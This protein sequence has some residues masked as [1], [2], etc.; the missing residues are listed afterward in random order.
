MSAEQYRIV[1]DGELAPG[2]SADAVRSNLARLFKSDSAKIDRL[3]G[4]GPVNIK[5]DLSAPEADRY[6]QA[7][8]R[9]GAL[10]R[11]ELEAG[12][13]IT[14]T[15]AE[16]ESSQIPAPV[17]Q[18]ACPKCGH[19]QPTSIQCNSCGIVIQKYLARQAQQAKT[20]GQS[21]SPLPSG[22]PYAPPRTPVDE[23]MTEHGELRV[24]T[25]QG[26]IGR[27]R[28]LAWSMGLMAAAFGLW[29][30]AS[31]TLAVSVVLG[32][33]LTG[34]LGLGFLVVTVQIGVQRLHDL[35]WSGWL[36]L[37]NLV[38]VVGTLFP[39]VM[40]LMPGNDGM[41]RFGAPQPPNSRAVKIL[42]ALW[43]LV[44]VIG[45]LAAI[46]LPSVG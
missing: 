7:L 35:G 16:H 44:P 26:R 21:R 42:A 30:I 36:M 5:R 13:E 32:V 43:L 14:L 15:L 41:N 19:T 6:M 9:A 46:V 33:I 8:E 38:P 45:I 34:V 39:F 31:M 24:F 11:K 10:A 18:I 23:L 27:L 4:N 22:Q 25:T 2:M 3:F 37:L 28:Y 29:M 40:L 20:T 1:F 17:T 12:K